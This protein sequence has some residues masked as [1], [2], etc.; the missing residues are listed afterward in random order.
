M[1]TF[2]IET[3]SLADPSCATAT[4]TNTPNGANYAT[5][6]SGYYAQVTNYTTIN[7]WDPS[8]N[9]VVD[10]YN[11]G[12]AVHPYMDPNGNYWDLASLPDPE[13][14]RG[15]QDVLI[16]QDPSNADIYYYDVLTTYA[17]RVRYTVTLET[18]NLNTNF[19]AASV[20]SEFTGTMQVVASIGPDGSAYGF[21]YENGTYG[22]LSGI[23]LPTGASVSYVY[24]SGVNGTRAGENVP[25]NGRWLGEHL[26][27]RCG[28]QDVSQQRRNLHA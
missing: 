5:D 21:T 7:V 1:H 23:T 20:G 6:G 12:N 4:I 2:P 11:G 22:E 26:H 8:G 25:L 13:D 17:K 16:S 19:L 27:L 15:Q 24:L 18:I 10:S 14:D 9:Q 3:I 28:W